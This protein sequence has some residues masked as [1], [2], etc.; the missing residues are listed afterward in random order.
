MSRFLLPMVHCSSRSATSTMRLSRTTAL[1][2]VAIVVVIC[3]LNTLDVNAFDADA[4]DPETV[5]HKRNTLDPTCRHCSHFPDDWSAC[6]VC[7]RRWKYVPYYAIK[8]RLSD[9]VSFRTATYG[10]RCCVDS[11]DPVCCETCSSSDVRKR[12]DDAGQYKRGFQT[13]FYDRPFY[14]GDNRCYC[15][16]SEA[17]NFACCLSCLKRRRR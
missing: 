14:S 4:D 2:A 1:L 17:F 16:R 11:G 10:C 7:H 15:C 13:S 5:V 3:F 8:K 12:G 9:R 6:Y